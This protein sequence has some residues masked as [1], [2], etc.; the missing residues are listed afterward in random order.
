MSKIIFNVG[1][2]NHDKI[3]AVKLSCNDLFLNDI[4]INAYETI[5]PE[6]KPNPINFETFEGSKARAMAVW[7]LGTIAIGIENGL[8]Y[9]DIPKLY[10]DIA[11]VTLINTYGE[12]FYSM[13]EGIQIPFEI[14]NEVIQDQNKNV[15]S[16]LAKKYGGYAHDA[17]SILT[18]DRIHRCELLHSAVKLAMLNVF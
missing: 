7:K 12:Y 11:I 14:A 16:I 2:L 18:F 10:F 4:E 5:I 8:F 13:S 17:Q 9:F 1:S 6:I 15:G 3:N